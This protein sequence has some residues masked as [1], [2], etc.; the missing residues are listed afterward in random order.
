MLFDLPESLVSLVKAKREGRLN[1]HDYDQDHLQGPPFYDSGDRN[2]PLFS[3]ST[4][5]ALEIFMV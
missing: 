4:M 5:P 1:P 2:D 3:Q